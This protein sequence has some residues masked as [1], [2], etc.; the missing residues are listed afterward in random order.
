LVYRADRPS[1]KEGLAMADVTVISAKIP[2]DLAAKVDDLAARRLVSS[3][4]LVRRALERELALAA[5]AD[6]VEVGPVEAAARTEIANWGF[7]ASE[8]RVATALN[9]AR[10]LD[11]DPTNGATHARELRALLDSLAGASTQQY[12]AVDEAKARIVLR[13]AGYGITKPDGTVLD[14]PGERRDTWRMKL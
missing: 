1:S 14:V 5:T 11:T 8:T 12:D 10:R 2:V 6:G 7:A 13:M 9:L 3:S 4:A